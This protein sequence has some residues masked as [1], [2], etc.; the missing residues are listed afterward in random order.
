MVVCV[1]KRGDV[2][3]V[4]GMCSSSGAAVRAVAGAVVDRGLVCVGSLFST[5]A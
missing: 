5:R 3:M 4:M 1:N 2:D